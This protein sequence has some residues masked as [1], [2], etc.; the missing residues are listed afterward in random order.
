MQLR[1][2]GPARAFVAKFS[3]RAPGSKRNMGLAATIISKQERF[4]ETRH[5]HRAL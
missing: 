4:C 2:C 5:A 3:L 1:E